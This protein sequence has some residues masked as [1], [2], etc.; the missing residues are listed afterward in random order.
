MEDEILYSKEITN[1]RFTQIIDIVSERNDV[2]DKKN[3]AKILGFKSTQ[4]LKD[5]EKNVVRVSSDVVG[6]MHQL[7]KVDANYF[8]LTEEQAEPYLSAYKKAVQTFNQEMEKSGTNTQFEITAQNFILN[9]TNVQQSVSN[10]N[11]EHWRQLVDAQ[12]EHIADLKEQIAMMKQ[13]LGKN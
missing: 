6:L 10:I 12:K 1:K 8:F 7:F 11:E 2:K 13:L 3:L 9:G 5:I 4:S